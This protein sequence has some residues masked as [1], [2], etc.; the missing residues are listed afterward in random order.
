MSRD[1][2]TLDNLESEKGRLGIVDSVFQSG[3]TTIADISSWAKSLSDKESSQFAQAFANL[4]KELVKGILEQ[5]GGGYDS[6]IDSLLTSARSFNEKTWLV[7]DFL[8]LSGIPLDECVFFAIRAENDLFAELLFSVAADQEIKNLKMA[9]MA[10]DLVLEHSQLELYY[11]AQY[12]VQFGDPD[13]RTA[14]TEHALKTGLCLS[15]VLSAMAEVSQEESLQLARKIVATDEKD[16][17]RSALE[18]IV[19]QG[20]DGDVK[21][22]QHYGS[23]LV[24]ESQAKIMLRRMLRRLGY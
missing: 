17:A 22:V 20:V 16:A 23:F 24:G 13:C 11:A 18:I 6:E 21:L 4:R 5:N 2:L 10:K 9:D 14:I 7:E 12:G 3:A 15:P 19:N 8:N 1:L